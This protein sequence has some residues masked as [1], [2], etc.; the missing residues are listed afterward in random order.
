MA[1]ARLLS[2]TVVGQCFGFMIGS[3]LFA[4]GSAPGFVSWA[5]STVSNMM[6]FAGAWF[7]TAAALAQLVLSGGRRVNPADWWAAAVQF[8]G[9]LLFNVSTAAALLFTTVRARQD[10]VWSPDAGGSVAFL[11]SGVLVV[12][13]YA[14]TR[15][16]RRP[17]DPAW[18]S[19]S[20]NFLGCMAFGVSAAGAII[21]ASGATADTSVATAGTFVGAVC[22]F[23]ASAVILPGALQQERL[24]R[25]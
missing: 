5:G 9:T 8:F 3:S 21:S 13:A 19:A 15:G 4:V 10:L 1:A 16:F 20:I 17:S 7:F 25:A 14:R 6:F 24:S 18:W 11:V 12:Y 22:F 2:P 23:L